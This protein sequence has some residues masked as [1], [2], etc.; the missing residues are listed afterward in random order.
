MKEGI[1]LEEETIPIPLGDGRNAVICT[2]IP[3]DKTMDSTPLQYEDPTCF[4][5]PYLDK[6][7]TSDYSSFYSESTALQDYVQVC[8]LV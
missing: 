3:V 5:G 7:A 8:V 2:L 6:F 4:G 1:F